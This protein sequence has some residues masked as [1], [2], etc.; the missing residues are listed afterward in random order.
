MVEY[1]FQGDEGEK[2]GKNHYCFYVILMSLCS[3]F[4]CVQKIEILMT[5]C[6]G[7]DIPEVKVEKGKW[8]WF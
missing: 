4:V 7:L 1:F 8:S 5:M 2:G 3:L 6:Y